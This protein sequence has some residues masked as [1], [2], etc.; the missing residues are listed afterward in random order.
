MRFVCNIKRRSPAWSA[1]IVYRSRELPKP[2]QSSLIAMGFRHDHFEHDGDLCY[3]MQ[4]SGHAPKQWDFS[5]RLMSLGF[6]FV[7]L[8]ER[9]ECMKCATAIM[10]LHVNK[11]TIDWKL[12]GDNSNLTLNF[13][14]EN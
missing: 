2:I 3:E 14:Q 8:H 6:N 10:E 9:S 4:H 5:V 1:F 13:Y 11:Q 12:A 7:D